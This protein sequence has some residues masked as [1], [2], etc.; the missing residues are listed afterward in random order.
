MT[1]LH[2]GE[3][4]G[5]AGG[6]GLHQAADIDV[7]LGD[8]AVERSDHALIGLLLTQHLQL[9]LLRRDVRLRDGDRGLPRLQGLASMSPCCWVTQPC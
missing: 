8:D 5:A 6:I 9:R 2:D 4:E 1:S 3:H 7:A